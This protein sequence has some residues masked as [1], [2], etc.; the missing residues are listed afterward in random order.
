MAQHISDATVLANGVN[1]P[2]LGLGVYKA[3][4]GEEVEQAVKAALRIGYRSIDTAAFYGNEEGVG[5]AV[6]ESGIPRE[7][8]FITTKVWNS[9]QGYERTLA[10]FEASLQRLGMEYVDLYLIHWPVKGKYKETWRALET[11]Y[12]E[13]KARAIGVSNFQVH[14][15]EDLMADAEIKPMVNQVEFHPFL[16]QEKLRD[17]CRREGIQLEAWSPLMRGEVVNVPEIV[18]LAEKYGKTPA[19]IVLRWDL[20]HG[21]VTIPKSVREARI[22]ENADLFDFELSAEDM[23]KLDAL[24]RNHRFGPDPDNFNF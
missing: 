5:R 8:I 3:K 7:E 20:Q 15:L 9:D 4:E 14:H 6:R 13:G 17:F 11:L 2:W 16:T 18:E 21:V 24:N 1:M 19:Q 23:A 12:K 10:A 22:R